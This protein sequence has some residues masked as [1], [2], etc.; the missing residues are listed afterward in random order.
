MSE[1]WLSVVI[2][3]W[4]GRDLLAACLASLRTWL[5]YPHEI[6]LVDNASSDGTPEM[7]ARDF[8]NVRCIRNATNRGFAAANNQGLAASHGRFVAC[9]NP[10]TELRQEPFRKMID[11]LEAHPQ[12]AFLG[13][14]LLNPDGTHQ[15]S[16]RNFPT[17]ADQAITLLKLRKLLARKSVMRRYASD[18][19]AG[20]TQ[21]TPVDQVMGACM[22]FPRSVIETIGDLDEGYWIWFEEVDWCQRARRAGFEVMYFPGAQVV[23]HGGTSFGQVLSLRKQWWWLRSLSRYIGKYWPAPAAWSLRLLMPLSYAL[24]LLQTVFKPR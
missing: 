2:V 7:V 9:L 12:V 8:P 19:A 21:P 1:P 15:P 11:Y 14:H 13:P 22:V 4:N 18:P 3:S 20:A 24:T 16:V 17:W 10:D 5:T 23:H 6:I